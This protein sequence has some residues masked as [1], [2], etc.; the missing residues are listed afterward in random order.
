MLVLTRKKNESIMLGE[1]IEVVVLEITPTQVRLG[2]KAP[3]SCSVYRKEIFTAIQEENIKAAQ[4]SVNTN[5][6]QELKGLLQ[7][8]Q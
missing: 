3:K 7:K 5:I 1:D 4:Q 2:L 6:S 8:P